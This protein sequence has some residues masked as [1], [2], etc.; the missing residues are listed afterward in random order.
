MTPHDVDRFE[1]LILPFL[2]DAYTLARYLLRDEHDAQ[3]A[4]QDAALRAFRH[5]AGYRGGD[6]RAWFLTIVRNCCLT[7]RRHR[8]DDRVTEQLGEAHRDVARASRDTDADAVEQS[9][10]AAV[11]RAVRDLPMEFREVI[12]LR[13]LQGLSYAQI[14][15]V[16]GAPMGTTM[17]RLARA[18]K[19]LAAVLS[20][21]VKEAS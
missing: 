2:T 17:S 11:E 14:S 18:R 6:P 1:Q 21:N 12:V 10:R 7:V 9:E 13:E 8:R 4:V 16:T 20:P 15:E 5:F 19:R 3:D